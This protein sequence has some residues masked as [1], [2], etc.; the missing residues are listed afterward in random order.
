MKDD[1]LSAPIP[2]PDPKVKVDEHI[3]VEQIGIGIVIY[4]VGMTLSLC[5]FMR[6]LYTK[7]RV[8]SAD[9]KHRGSRKVILKPLKEQNGSKR[10][11]N[12]TIAHNMRHQIVRHK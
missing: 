5:F 3:S 11:H 12:I 8:K 6:E 2:I 4:S 1:E 7:R 10:G 9:K